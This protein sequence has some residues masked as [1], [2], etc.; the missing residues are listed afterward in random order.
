MAVNGAREP[1]GAPV[2]ENNMKLVGIVR[3]IEVFL[4]IS[5]VITGK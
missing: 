4:R 3:T 5:S 1:P 2:L